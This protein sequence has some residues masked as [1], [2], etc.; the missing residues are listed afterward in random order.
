MKAIIAEYVKQKL[1]AKVARCHCI[2]QDEKN[3]NIMDWWF[4]VTSSYPLSME[5]LQNNDDEPL[6]YCDNYYRIGDGDDVCG[7]S[8]I[9]SD[10]GVSGYCQ[11]VRVWVRRCDKDGQVMGV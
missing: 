2:Y 11:M 3:P 10:I 9:F 8:I 1:K 4:F 7:A 6:Q 5:P